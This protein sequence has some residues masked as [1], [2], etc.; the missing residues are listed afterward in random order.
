[1]TKDEIEL[2]AE[3]LPAST[4]LKLMVDSQQASTFTTTSKGKVEL[5]LSRKMTTR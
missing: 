5:K 2:T 3:G 1:V 4:A